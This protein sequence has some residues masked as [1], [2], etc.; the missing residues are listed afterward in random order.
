MASTVGST[1]ASVP[2]SFNQEGVN[3]CVTV[4]IQLLIRDPWTTVDEIL[5]YL[6]WIG[7]HGSARILMRMFGGRRTFQQ[8]L[9]RLEIVRHATIQRRLHELPLEVERFDGTI[10]EIARNIQLWA[11]QVNEGDRPF[12]R[13][14]P[15]D[16]MQWEPPHRYPHEGMYTDDLWEEQDTEDADSME[17]SAGEEASEGDIDDDFNMARSE[18]ST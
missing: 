4:M 8:T 9:E 10:P 11:P 15:G 1:A 17:G 6:L 18:A 3:L 12:L 14:P 13:A 2:D 16:S 7:P 5:N